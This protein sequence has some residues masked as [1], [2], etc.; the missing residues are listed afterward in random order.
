MK[1]I[2][3]ATLALV[4]FMTMWAQKT[5]QAIWTEGNT[6]LTFINSETVYAEGDTFNGE[7]VTNVWSGSQVTEVS[8]NTPPKWKNVSNKTVTSVVFDESFQDVKPTSTSQ[9]FMD[10][11][12]LTSIVG[13]EYLNTSMANSMFRMFYF[14]KLLTSI[15]VSHFDTSNVTSMYQMFSCC[16][17]LEQLDLSNFDTSKV[18]TMTGMFGSCTALKKLDISKFNTSSVTS[19]LEMFFNCS[20]LE[21]LDVSSF[22]TSNVT[23]LYRTFKGCSRLKSLDLS[24]FETPNLGTL[25]ETFSGCKSL[26]DLDIS[27][28]DTSKVTSMYATFQNCSALPSLDV[29][30][31]DT[32]SC[33]SMGTMF[34]GCLFDEIDVSNF[35]TSNVTIMSYMFSG[36]KNLTGIDVSQFD[37]SKVTTMSYMFSGC[38]NLTDLD[39][40]HFDT[41]KVTNMSYMFNDCNN[42]ENLDVSHFDTSKVTNMSYMFYSCLQLGNLDMSSF[43][44]QN[45]TT[46]RYMFARCFSLDS[47]DLSSFNTSKVTDM[48]S[49]FWANYS[50]DIN[51]RSF[52]TRNVTTMSYMFWSCPNLKELELRNFSTPKLRSIGGMFSECRS[53]YYIDLTGFDF[54]KVTSGLNVV[55]NTDSVFVYIPSGMPS[56]VL[57]YFNI[58][59]AHNLII[60]NPEEGF[61][62]RSCNL[63]DQRDLRLPYPFTANRV[64][65]FRKFV[66]GGNGNTIILPCDFTVPTGMRVYQMRPAANQVR[67]DIIYFQQQPWGEIMKANTPYLIAN[68]GAYDV[69]CMETNGPVEVMNTFDYYDLAGTTQ[70]TSYAGPETIETTLKD[71]TEVTMFGTFRTMPNAEV[72]DQGIYIFQ[73]GNKWKQVMSSN[74]SAYIRP[75]RAYLQ[76][77]GGSASGVSLFNSTLIDNEETTRVT[78]VPTTE[79][80]EKGDLYDLSGRR[81]A[82][83]RKGIYLSEGKKMVIGL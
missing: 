65:Y 23:T 25:A 76:K 49:M 60:G 61:T 38:K 31:F 4:S 48:S 16:S 40:S 24:N 46:M 51:V 21:T 54:S 18:T 10:S 75:Y 81:I 3:L 9:W 55:S 42:L 34:S 19:M 44:T 59:K 63:Y 5:P 35:D 83:P 70:L 26:V 82:N 71:G 37:T 79:G 8:D 13:L 53:L 6:T 80:T 32:S 47:L 78:D 56:T 67:D 68:W 50:K 62:C 74:T 30:H 15:D 72:A 52:D 77:V 12:M 27:N 64:N 66:N 14:C 7:T 45:V 33:T 17:G 57:E 73:T 2:L 28:F 69:I 58:S 39:V 41:S 36:C 11:E 43:N 22:D 20:A 29:R 1:R